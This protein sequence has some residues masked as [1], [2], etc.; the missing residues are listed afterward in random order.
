MAQRCRLTATAQIDGAVRAPGYEF[1]LGDGERGPHRTVRPVNPSINA[2]HVAGHDHAPDEG[3]DEAL[4]EVIGVYE[5]PV[6]EADRSLEGIDEGAPR[7]FGDSDAGEGE[8]AAEPAPE[9]E[10]LRDPT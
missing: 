10:A 7:V 3:E 8:A 9:G 2:S 5:E 1:V 4:Y 6:A